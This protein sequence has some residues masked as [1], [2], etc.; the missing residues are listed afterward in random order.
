MMA[1]GIL[2]NEKVV[3]NVMLNFMAKLANILPF[4]KA[5]GLILISNLESSNRPPR[6]QLIPLTASVKPD[7]A[8]T[9][10]R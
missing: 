3:A 9:N 8:Q 1:N 10:D 4:E 7:H 6:E 5:M 2:Q